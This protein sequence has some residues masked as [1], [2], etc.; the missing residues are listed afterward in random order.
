[1]ADTKRPQQVGS[2]QRMQDTAD[3]KAGEVWVQV[4]LLPKPA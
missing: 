3:G 1:M 4:E 2:N